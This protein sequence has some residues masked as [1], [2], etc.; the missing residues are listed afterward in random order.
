MTLALRIVEPSADLQDLAPS[1]RVRF[2]PASL[3]AETPARVGL[4]LCQIPGSSWVLVRPESAASAARWIRRAE[5]SPAAG[6][7]R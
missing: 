2:A 6:G 1:S 3:P 5:L 7:A 4:V